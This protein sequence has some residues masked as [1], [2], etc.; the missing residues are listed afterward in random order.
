[1]FRNSDLIAISPVFRLF[2]SKTA[3]T[4]ACILDLNGTKYE[5]T[6]GDTK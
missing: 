1:M 3:G 4:R 6:T 5:Q 2:L